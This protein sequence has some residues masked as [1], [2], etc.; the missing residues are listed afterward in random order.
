MDHRT[1]HAAASGH[2]G[3]LATAHSACAEAHKNL[4][5][6]ED[7]AHALLAAVRG[8]IAKAHSALADLHDGMC[9]QL[10]EDTGEDRLERASL[11]AGV[12]RF[13]GDAPGAKGMG[14]IVARDSDA[15]ALIDGDSEDPVKGLDPD[16]RKLVGAE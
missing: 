4:S 10:V 13:G 12:Q 7:H 9:E 5:A 11:P 8:K 3:N 6:T 1:F 2:H 15:Q 16:L 14:R